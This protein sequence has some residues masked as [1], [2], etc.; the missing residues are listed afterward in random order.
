MTL[1]FA[2]EDARYA[3][4]TGVLGLVQGE[5]DEKAG[6]ATWQV[7]VPAH[8]NLTTQPALASRIGE[9]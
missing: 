7:Y 4:L 6:R 9:E 1:V 5:F 2:T 3:W 8:A